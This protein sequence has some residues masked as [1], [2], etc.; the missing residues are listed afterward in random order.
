MPIIIAIIIGIISGFVS[1]GIQSLFISRRDQYHN[2]G[3]A[4]SLWKLSWWIGGFIMGL[5]IYYKYM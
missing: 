4:I 3:F 5:G 2:S 1:M